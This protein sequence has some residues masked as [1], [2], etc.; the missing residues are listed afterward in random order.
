MYWWAPTLVITSVHC[1]AGTILC[2][3]LVG[4]YRRAYICTLPRQYNTVVCIGGLLHP[5]IHLY[6]VPPVQH[7]H[8]YWW[9]PTDV[10]T[11][12]HCPASA[13]LWY[14]LVGSY[15]RAYICTLSHQYNT[16]ESIGGLLNPCIHL[17]I[18]TP[19]QY[20]GMYWWDPITCI[21]LYIVPPV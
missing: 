20:C 18:V 6:I 1:P 17:Y 8:M 7:C 11:S 14:V 2:Y 13:T 12:V 15:T 21:H 5:C 16:V 9:N 19:V 3:V 4:S 10:H